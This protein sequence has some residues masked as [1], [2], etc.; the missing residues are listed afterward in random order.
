MVSFV[1][2]T[3]RVGGK[4]DVCIT[5]DGARQSHQYPLII[6]VLRQV[7]GWMVEYR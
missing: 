2:V 4:S 1:E 5:G 6:H 7:N 3:E